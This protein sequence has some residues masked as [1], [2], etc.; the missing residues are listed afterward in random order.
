[1]TSRPYPTAG[2]RSIL[3]VLD[4]AGYVEYAEF[5]H[6]RNGYFCRTCTKM[7]STLV[8]TSGG[9]VGY[10]CRGLEVPV[11]PWGCCNYWVYAPPEDRVV[12]R[13]RVLP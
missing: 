6:S 13:D 5:A 2:R 7:D 1:M 8:Q 9:F 4:D 10:Y 11:A 3:H 12:L